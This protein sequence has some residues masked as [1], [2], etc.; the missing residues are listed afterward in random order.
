M[1]LML[2][3]FSD[4]YIPS[5]VLLS[6]AG[7]SFSLFMVSAQTTLQ[8]LLP[9]GFRGRVMAIWGMNYGVVFPLGQMQM[10]FVAGLSR[11]HLSGLL[12]SYAGAPSAIIL[13]TVIMLAFS[14]LGVVSKPMVRNLTPQE[15]EAHR[16][17]TSQG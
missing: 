7:I 8:Y 14:L 16:Q 6:L 17:S 13:G 10:G 1:F 9:D 15:L 11:T 4:S 12:G 5:L 2:F 3:A